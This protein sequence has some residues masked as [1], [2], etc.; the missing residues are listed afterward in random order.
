MTKSLIKGLSISTG[1]HNMI[2][3]VLSEQGQT[4][5]CHTIEATPRP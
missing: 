4:H 3:S 2:R 5:K 1:S